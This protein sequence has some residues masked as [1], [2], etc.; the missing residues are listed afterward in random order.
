MES[1]QGAMTGK[2]NIGVWLW[3]MLKYDQFAVKIENDKSCFEDIFATTFIK[4]FYSVYIQ[5]RDINNNKAYFSI[6]ISGKEIMFL[7]AFVY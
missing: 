7:V 4:T 6:I 1:D 2:E 5:N 3:N